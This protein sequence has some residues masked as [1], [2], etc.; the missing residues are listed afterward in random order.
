MIIKE[1]EGG[2]PMKRKAVILCFALV[3]VGN[4]LLLLGCP[5]PIIRVRP[6]EPRVEVYGAPPYPE[7]VWRPG[8]WE[9]RRGTWVWVD[10]HW[11]RPPRPHAVWVPGQWEPRRGGWVWHR[12][13][14][15][16]R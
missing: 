10:G 12:G 3:L 13:H 1:T 8:Q 9:Y 2:T 7:A 5:P 14:W 15:E 6:P 16:S 4:L 11:T